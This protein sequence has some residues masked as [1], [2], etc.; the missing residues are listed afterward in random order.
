M[1]NADADLRLADLTEEEMLQV[2]ADLAQRVDLSPCPDFGLGLIA[3]VD[4]TY[5]G[6]RRGIVSIVVFDQLHVVESR[7]KVL[8]INQPY[9]PGFLAFRE[10]PAILEA[11][12]ELATEPDI[13]AFDGNGVLHDRRCGLATHASFHLGK[14]TL[15][16]TK[17]PHLGQHEE[18]AHRAGS[19][20]PVTDRGEMV[21]YCMR[22]SD[23]TNPV[24]VS[25]GNGMSHEQALGIARFYL[26][27]NSR[28]PLLT[29]MP[30]K[31]SRAE[32]RRLESE[33]AEPKPG[34]TI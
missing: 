11:V 13:Y 19:A 9:I 8:E 2:Q 5:H 30:D 4:I 18:P 17:K 25:V 31:L 7:I 26:N 22:G 23:G 3:G 28:I 21:G 1:R 10:L 27:P 15:G 34:L 6:A 20:V 32:R 16:I 29:D 24:Y 33:D 12:S 14:P